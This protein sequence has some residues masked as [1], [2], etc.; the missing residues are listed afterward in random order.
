LQGYYDRK[1]YGPV[2]VAVAVGM[3]VAVGIAVAYS[4]VA[5]GIAVAYSWVEAGSLHVTAGR[6]ERLTLKIPIIS[7]RRYIPEAAED[8]NVDEGLAG[9]IDWHSF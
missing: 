2:L 5:V 7:G 9:S 4:W 6:C 3:M 1:E 8:H